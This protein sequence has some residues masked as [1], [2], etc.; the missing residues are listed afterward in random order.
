MVAA[1]LLGASVACAGQR[2]I[3]LAD[4]I[5]HSWANELI[6][7]PL[8]FEPGAC[9]ESSVELVGPDGPAAF[10]LSDEKADRDGFLT[11]ARL[12]FLTDLPAL[13]EVKYLVT[14][15]ADK[16]VKDMPATDLAVSRTD[17]Q[18]EIT[19]QRSGIRLLNGKREYADLVASKDVPGPFLGFRTLE[20]KWV[21]GSALYGDRKIA[22]YDAGLEELGPLF[23]TWRVVYTYEDGATLAF[24]ARMTAEQEV[25]FLGSESSAYLPD[26]GMRLILNRNYE[27]P[28]L[29]VPYQKAVNLNEQPVGKVI[30]N[31]VPWEDWWNDS[32]RTNFS[33]SS[34]QS[35]TVLAIGSYDPAAWH[36][37][38][39]SDPSRRDEFPFMPKSHW[40]LQTFKAMHV[41]RDS[42][43]KVVLTC[44]A[45]LGERKWFIG[46]LPLSEN[47]DDAAYRAMALH[48]SKYGCQT[49]DEVKDYVLDWQ[50]K[51][52]VIHPHLYVARQDVEEARKKLGNAANIEG[53]FVRKY[54]DDEGKDFS[55]SGRALIQYMVDSAY[56]APRHTSGPGGNLNKFDLMRHASWI[57]HL[58]DALMGTDEV[59][60][61]DAK[62]MR[63]QLAFLGYRLNSPYVWDM[64]RGFAGDPNNMHIAYM[65]NLGMVAC[66][67]P[68]HPMAQQW[69]HKALG[70][71]RKRMSEHVGE[72][73]VWTSENMHYA[74]VSFTYILAFAIATQNA[75]FYDFLTK[76]DKVRAWALYIMKQQ[77]APDPR[78]NGVRSQPEQVVD[79]WYEV[80][81]AN[82]GILAKATRYL[83]PALSKVMQWV[84]KE[85]GYPTNM[86]NNLLGCFIP[87]MLDK[88]LPAFRPDWESEAFP[89]A[90]IIMRHGLGTPDE[91]YLCLPICDRPYCDYYL[92]QP[93]GLTIAGKGKPLAVMF[94]ESTG[95][96]FISNSV[97]MARTPAKTKEGRLLNIGY[98]GRAK[99][100]DFSAMGRQ[101]YAM[102]EY[103]LDQPLKGRAY[104]YKDFH[105]LPE[106]PKLVN[107][108]TRGG[109]T[110]WRQVLFIKGATAADPSYFLFRDTT[111][112][113]NQ[114]H[115]GAG[116]PTEPTTWSLWTLSQKIGTSDDAE[117]VE[118]FLGDAPGNKLMP[119]RTL[120]GD[121]FTSV[122]R[123]DV[124]VEYF[125]ALPQGTPRST[126]RWGYETKYDTREWSEY[127]DML[128]LQLASDGVYFVA[129]YP[130]RRNEPAPTFASVGDRR[131]IKTQGDFG[132]DYGFL[133]AEKADAMA[134]NVRF[135]GTAGSVQDRTDGLV[136]SLGAT[137]E[138]RYKG[139]QVASDSAVSV[140]I[141]DNTITIVTS[142]DRKEEQ[143]LT[144]KTPAGDQRIIIP[145][146][147]SKT[148]LEMDI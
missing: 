64:E 67:F 145:V 46:F 108:A 134:A 146:G 66:M 5:N 2:E 124:D 94:A 101:D 56:A 131:I 35:R 120:P 144:L 57:L 3:R 59:T 28:V 80:R 81:T 25:V 27:A 125:V 32:T 132:T 138:V 49:L 99:I 117:N 50:S 19:T 14:F 55:V 82:A 36:D 17:E 129:F 26:D 61:E 130:R 105:K 95:E 118:A 116:Q 137:G 73:G 60:P 53:Q 54:R 93:G 43:R 143:V 84:W 41:R 29:R 68:E 23:A 52:D 70:E 126:V 89:T 21:G 18:I 33:L 20:G 87:V 78:R 148:T 142:P 109:V 76:D 65:F 24:T 90:N 135:I 83:D 1:M 39:W 10:Q 106:W 71:I 40:Q 122:G 103:H 16:K 42:D 63:S 48:D 113:S 75:R 15:D 69:I 72:N 34:P 139:Y 62:L 4:Y 96:S 31:L 51:R 74:K 13:G 79:A 141:A 7:Y 22:S 77:T 100:A 37:P 119:A 147:R 114:W 127:Q 88:S 92:P 98:H 6:A 86:M 85:Q 45:Q 123:F 30:H 104:Y 112:D 97:D 102:A 111:R 107:T 47:P 8:T 140:T 110:C 38:A 128:H 44:S 133:S 12:S 115:M 58:Y 136:L 11:S 91:Y 121:R 9:H